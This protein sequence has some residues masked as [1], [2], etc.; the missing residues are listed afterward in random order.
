MDACR[1]LPREPGECYGHVM[2][3]AQER[4]AARRASWT[5][6]VVEPGAPKGPLYRDLTPQQRFAAFTAL[7]ARVWGAAWL[8][9]GS[10]PRSQWPGEIFECPRH[11]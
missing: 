10:G 1:S 4:A 8:A 11:D 5:A 7:Q 3:S 9:L 2:S 6:E